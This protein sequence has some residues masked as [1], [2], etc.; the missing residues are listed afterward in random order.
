MASSVSIIAKTYEASQVVS[1]NRLSTLIENETI[2]KTPEF[3]SSDDPNPVKFRLELYFG[4][5]KEGYLSVYVRNQSKRRVHSDHFSFTM[6]TDVPLKHWN[7]NSFVFES[8]DHFNHPGSE[9]RR[10]SAWG[11]KH[12]YKLSDLAELKTP[13]QEWDIQILFKIKYVGE[14]KETS[15]NNEI[16][17]RYPPRKLSDDLLNI[18]TNEKDTDV[19]FL[20]NGKLVH[21]V[22]FCQLDQTTLIP[23]F[24]L[25]WWKPILIRLR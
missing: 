13:R 17:V 6:S 16:K 20:V 15:K 10:Y 14:F 11:N 9:N 21:I 2:Q 3:S 5:Y 1:L 12:F 22:T 24:T 18:F 8:M 19:S 7:N 25:G 4:S 23:C